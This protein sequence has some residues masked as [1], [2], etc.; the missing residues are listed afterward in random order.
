MG[1]DRNM[2]NVVVTGHEYTDVY[3]ELD[4]VNTK[5]WHTE[6]WLLNLCGE[7]SKCCLSVV[8][9]VLGS[10]DG[11]S[12]VEM[13]YICSA[14]Q[15]GVGILKLSL[16]HLYPSSSCASSLSKVSFSVATK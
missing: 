11:F 14:L 5:W 3:L 15:R 8:G 4:L 6:L 10:K 7:Y 12:F 13:W 2:G 16:P 1:K 9:G